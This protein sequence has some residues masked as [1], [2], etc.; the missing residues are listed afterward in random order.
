M[1]NENLM[2][3]IIGYKK[4]RTLNDISYNG[5]VIVKAGFVFDV[6]VPKMIWLLIGGFM[7]TKV[8]RAVAVHDYEYTVKQHDRRLVDKQLK[9]MLIA[10]GTNVVSAWIAYIGARAVGW[11][12]WNKASQEAFNQALVCKFQGLIE[13]K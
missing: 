7:F 2:I 3:E 9:D 10:D 1:F 13:R 4:Y 11:Y 6:T 8:I 12:F 5:V